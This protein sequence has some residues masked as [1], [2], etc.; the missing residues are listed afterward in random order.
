GSDEWRPDTRVGH[1]LE[2]LEWMVAKAHDV[3]RVPPYTSLRQSAFDLGLPGPLSRGLA[4]L[5]EFRNQF[6]HGHISASYD[7]S[8]DLATSVGRWLNNYA[9]FLGSELNQQRPGNR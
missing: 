8:L 6:V 1:A 3:M 4:A 9:D 5:A 2:R 7:G